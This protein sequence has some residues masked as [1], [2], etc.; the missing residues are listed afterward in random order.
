VSLLLAA[1]L[2]IGKAITVYHAGHF[3][4]E[5]IPKEKNVAGAPAWAGSKA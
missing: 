3:I 4:G 5:F 1:S 2:A